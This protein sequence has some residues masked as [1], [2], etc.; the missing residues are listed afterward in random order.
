MNDVFKMTKWHQSTGTFRSPPLVDPQDP[1]KYSVVSTD[2]KR[3]QLIK[4]LLTNT[5]E[6]GDIPF[7][8]PATAPRTI[9]FPETTAQDIRKAILKAGNTAPGIDD[10]PTNILNLPGL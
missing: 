10:I 6:V 1:T 5:A 8:S 7:D 4:E 3:T 2:E 9:Q